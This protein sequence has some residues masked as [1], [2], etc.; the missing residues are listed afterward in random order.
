MQESSHRAPPIPS[1]DNGYGWAGALPEKQG[2][3]D[4]ANERDA[5]GVG[6]I[7]DIKGAA[8]HQLLHDSEDLLC[9]MSHRGATGADE[10]DGDGAGVM[11][12]MPHKFMTR[13]FKNLGCLLPP[14]GQYATGNVF[15]HQDDAIRQESM[16]VFEKTAQQIGLKTVVWR[17]VPVGTAILGPNGQM[18]EPV[19]MQPLVVAI[20]EHLD[21]ADF[22]RRLFVLRKRAMR[23]IGL[24]KWFYVCSLATRNIVYKGLLTPAQVPE[25]YADLR[26]S[27]FETHFAL[28]HS[29]FSTNTFPSWE[30]AQP[31]NWCAHNGEINTLRGN[32]NWMR[33]REGLLESKAFGADL[34]SAFPI[35]N[36]FG[37]D[38]SAFDSVLELLVVSGAM[39]MPEAVMVM[40]PEAWQNNPLMP[41]EKRAFYEWASCIMEPWDGPALFTFSDGRY[42]GASLD[43]NGLRPCRYYVTKDDRM[44]CA[45]EVG[46]VKIDPAMVVQ[47][48][49]LMPGRM[50]LVDTKAGT[51]VDDEKLK[52]HYAQQYPFQKWID[53]NQITL[54]HLSPSHKPAIVDDTPV[55]RDRRLRVFGYSA[56]QLNLIL[57][58]MVQHGKEPLGSMGN[59]TV[60]ACL[61]PSPRLPYEYFR[62]LFA[63]VTNPPI[64]PIREKMVMS[65]RCHVGPEGNLLEVSEQQTHRLSLDSP[66]LTCGE[67]ESICKMSSKYPDW[68]AH[69]L[70]ITYDVSQG[71]D[72]YSSAIDRVCS[73]TEKAIAD[74]A[75]VIVLSDRA[76]G[77]TRVALSALLASGAVHH[78]LVAQKLRAKVALIVETGEARETHHFCVLVGYGVDAVCPYMVY[79][80]VTK[81]H[82]ENVLADKSVEEQV[83]QFRYAVDDGFRK[84]MS[85][86]GISTL[87]SYKGAQIFE[88]LGIASEV[89]D[90]CF[91][92]TA[93]RVEGTTMAGFAADALARH[94]LAYVGKSAEQGIAAINDEG[95]YNWRKGG[96]THVNTPGSIASLQDAVRTKNAQS[97]KKYT[98]SAAQSIRDC[99]LRGLLDIDADDKSRAIP[100]EEVEPWTSI[101]KRFCTGAMSYGSISKEA[102]TTLAVAMN[103][104]GGKSNSGEGGEDPERSIPRQNGDSERSAIK[105]IASG[106]FGV[107][108]NYLADAD[109]LQ[110]KMAQGAKA[111]E[112]GELLGTKVSKEIAKTRHTTPGVTLVS[113]PPHHD[114]Y[115]IEDLKQLIFDLKS[116]NSGARVSVK[117][118]SEVGI[119]VVA[120]GVA[121]A[122]ADHIL[123]AGHD[124]GTGAARWTG[125]K[126]A[127][128]PWELG[129]AETHQ[130]LVLNDLRGRVVLQT[131]GQLKTAKDIAIATLLG[132]EEFGFA[133]TPLITLGC[134]YLRRC[135]QNNCA[136]GVATQDPVLRAKF[137]GQPE[138][139]IN[140]FSYLAED[141]RQIMADLGFRTVNEMVGRAEYL[142]VRNDYQCAK[143]AIDLGLLLKPAHTMRPGVATYSVVKQDHQIES[144]LDSRLLPHLVESLQTG[145]PAELSTEIQNTDRAFGT[146]LSYHLSK[147]HGLDGLP[148]GTIR[149]HLKGSAG[150]S[151]GAFL[152]PGIAIDLEGDANDY[153]GKGLSGGQLVVYPPRSSSFDASNNVIVGNVCLFGATSGEAFFSG[154]AAE[155]FAVRNSGALAVVEGVG[156]HGCEY[157]TGGRVIVL[158]NVGRNFAAGM[159][160][161]IAY[162]LADDFRKMC[163]T[164]S[165]E[166]ETVH[167]DEAMWLKQTIQRHLDLTGSP[168]AREVVRNFGEVLPQF[169]KVF[170]IE[171]K[172]ILEDEEAAMKKAARS[173]TVSSGS[174]GSD[175]EKTIEATD[176]QDN[177]ANKLKSVAVNDLVDIEDAL[178][179]ESLLSD[180]FK[181]LDKLRGFVKYQR[182]GDKYRNPKKRVNDWDEISVRQTKA[183]L[184]VQ[185]SRCIDC[186]VPFCQSD[187]DGCP[188]GNVIPKWNE[189]VF[190]NQWREAFNRL[191][192]TN[193]FPEFTGRVCPAPCEGAC[194]AGISELP[195]AIKSIEAAIIDHAWEMG[196]MQPAPPA[197]RTGMKVAIVGSGPAGLSAADQLNSVGH[198]VTVFER[199]DRIGG[200]LTYGIPNMKL[201]K[202]LVH[203]RVDKMQKEGVQFVTGAHIGV[204]HSAADLYDSHDA[205]LLATGATWPRDLAIDGRQLNGI[206]FAMEYLTG[207]TKSVLGNGEKNK[208]SAEGKRVVVIGG[209]DTGN[210][211]IGT[212]V[213][214]GATSVTNFE[215]LPQPPKQRAA[216]NPWPQYPRV[217]RVD[218]GHEEVMTRWGKDPREYCISAKRFVSGDG[219]NGQQLNGIETV[220]VEW[221]KKEN[222]QWSMAEVPGSEEFHGADLV[223]LAMGFLGPENKVIEELAVKQGPRSNIQTPE[224][225]YRTTVDKVFAAGDC[226]RGQSLVVWGINEGRQAAREI[227]QYLHKCVS[228]HLPVSGGIVPR[229]VSVP[230]P[231]TNSAKQVVADRQFAVAA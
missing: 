118:V 87:Q 109:E 23:E 94:D 8:S 219:D 159:S 88:A 224:G 199:E 6:F 231:Q 217:Y 115:S 101:V 67:L 140:F 62:E 189:L 1:N 82:R 15:L 2:L 105:Q 47:K 148:Q 22:Q 180:R 221:T 209:G 149:L 12:A 36:E 70:D 24:D 155:R 17:K 91:V 179:D 104:L 193:N 100:V 49:R 52:I 106:R 181:K 116:S 77:P 51:I 21:E 34:Q 225:S 200:L 46:T 138:H 119:G 75:K 143:G 13:E 190:K 25:Y 154:I 89:I 226:R 20:A 27:D 134:V 207:N 139:V 59:D 72:G 103:R 135:H 195:V 210:D 30:R 33:A 212:A 164:E 176:E 114:I 53:E 73:E 215:L 50:L 165:V 213:R 74:G 48:G 145:K 216:D 61:D 3:Y 71:I 69:T 31:F 167:G 150:Q 136:V 141:L 205:V 168:K 102:H 80:A 121:K 211:C 95:E 203:R 153:V 170:P 110:I 151:L 178:V 227:D 92:G 68:T 162:V 173:S 144:R 66:L 5:C 197:T 220:R 41:A 174:S 229:T 44:I 55:S 177:I 16:Q 146:I 184:Q 223:F 54:E 127:G 191:M 86:M 158:G 11:A 163:N 7:I 129:L 196:W 222:G 228:S 132:A 194:V 218:Y 42:C 107:T 198:S 166:L 32:M 60:L 125:I 37:S 85:K 81:L 39:S 152:A 123:I 78:H 171:Y 58:P 90:K 137:R 29:R 142:R 186:G 187:A 38:S 175:S 40:V 206:H 131:D 111:G 230:E 160:G 9:N 99:T 35:I 56:E 43:R 98:D 117:L 183:Q 192:A 4:P 122:L 128:L 83:E 202:R 161:G 112:G 97:W 157:M 45:S 185:A 126:Y 93:S 57:T 156:D 214:Q 19:V 63:Q 120:S 65:L 201:D 10:R 28:V 84:V 124:G 133:T 188:I 14:E 130:T 182:R 26:D 18:C 79:E 204:T 169:V 76:V 108:S 172:R 96:E 208:I 147:S 64:D 113:P